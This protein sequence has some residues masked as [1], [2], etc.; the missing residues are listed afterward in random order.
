MNFKGI[1]IYVLLGLV[2][3]PEVYSVEPIRSLSLVKLAQM[4]ELSGSQGYLLIDLNLG[5][6]AP[7]FI[8]AKVRSNKTNAK[9]VKLKSSQ[10][11]DF[12]SIGL[13][14]KSNGLYVIALK[15]GLYQI[16]QVNVPFYDLPFRYETDNRREWRFRIESG[17]VNYIGQLLVEGERHVDKVTVRLLNRIATDKVRI[18]RELSKIP[19]AYSLVSSPGVRDDFYSEL[20]SVLQASQKTNLESKLGS[21]P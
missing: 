21:N 20:V 13:K 4:S 14:N 7:S 18:E 17:K 9:D 11:K 19:F 16:S 12:T 5:G 8:F 2:C 6:V 1:A 10:L 3:P 15:S